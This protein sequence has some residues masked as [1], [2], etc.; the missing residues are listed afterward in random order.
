MEEFKSR[1]LSAA[2]PC[3]SSHCLSTSS[4]P[5]FAF[6][7]MT[8]SSFFLL[9]LL[10]DLQSV[11]LNWK[12]TWFSSPASSWLHK[13]QHASSCEIWTRL[14]LCFSL[15][16]PL[17]YFLLSRSPSLSVLLSFSVLSFLFIRCKGQSS[18]ARLCCQ[19]PLFTKG[20]N[21]WLT[22]TASFIPA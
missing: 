8:S 15:F 21:K 2:H 20:R 12:M 17:T 9:P 6:H 10:L 3:L 11:D 7:R 22:Q 1:L 13:N 18:A 5:F 16:S 4:L 14:L 19:K